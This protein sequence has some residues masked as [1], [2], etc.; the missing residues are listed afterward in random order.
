[1]VDLVMLQ[2]VSYVAASI[3]VCFAAIYYV[4]T[5]RVQQTNMKQTLVKRQAQLFTQIFNLYISSGF[6]ANITEIMFNWEWTDFEDFRNK[7][8]DRAHNKEVTRIYTDLETYID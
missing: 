2:S 4:M 7:Y 5:L 8:G 6:S 1:M 3:G